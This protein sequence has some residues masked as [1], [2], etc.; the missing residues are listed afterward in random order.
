MEIIAHFIRK[1][2]K[3]MFVSFFLSNSSHEWLLK[4]IFPSMGGRCGVYST[5]CAAT[6]TKYSFIVSTVFSVVFP[7]TIFPVEIYA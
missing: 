4:R 2:G 7:L 3:N 1:K 6:T 5:I